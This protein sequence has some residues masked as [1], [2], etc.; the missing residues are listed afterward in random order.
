MARKE[1]TQLTAES[2]PALTVFYDGSCPLCR[3]EIGWYQKRSGAERVHWR[4]IS[5]EGESFS[6]PGLCYESAMARFHVQTAH[7]E[8][9]SGALGFAEV[10]KQLPSFRWLGHLVSAPG[11]RVIAEFAYRGFL[12][13][14]PVMQRRFSEAGK[15]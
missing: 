13:V 2:T 10:W 11:I 3:R 12:R 6:V 5:I 4:D 15:G 9:M 8:L 14:R 1:S 7:G